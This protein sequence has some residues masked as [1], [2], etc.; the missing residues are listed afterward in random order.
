M[1]KNI[2]DIIQ[3]IENV[4]EEITAQ[5]ADHFN[6]KDIIL[7]FGKSDLLCAFLRCAYYG[8]PD[9]AERGP[10]AK[11]FEVLVAETAPLFTGHVTAKQL[12]EAGL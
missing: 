4:Y 3:D 11:E 10:G 1:L 5:A 6:P 8:G 2:D 9:Q 7:T 12:Q